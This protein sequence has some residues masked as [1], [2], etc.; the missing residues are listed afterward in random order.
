[1]AVRSSTAAA[2]L[3]PSRMAGRKCIQELEAVTRL[4][5]P[6]SEVRIPSGALLEIAHLRDFF[7]VRPDG[8]GCLGDP[9]VPLQP[10]D[11]R[12]HVHASA[13]SARFRL[14]RVEQGR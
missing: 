7:A 10:A 6:R 11:F 14:A 9:W 1:M 8:D 4:R 12:L 2:E 5:N 3:A 13:S